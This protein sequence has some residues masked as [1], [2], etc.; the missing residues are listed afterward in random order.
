[1]T[2]ETTPKKRKVLSPEE[3][4]AKAEAEVQAMRERL[5][6]RDLDQLDKL[7]AMRAK[8]MST[9][10]SA[11]AKLQEIDTKIGEIEERLG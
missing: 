6:K 9:Y 1:M 8:A 2:E 3:R 10:L 4:L 11:E 5:R 7:N